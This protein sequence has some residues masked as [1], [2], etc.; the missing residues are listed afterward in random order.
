MSSQQAKPGPESLWVPA[1]FLLWAEGAGRGPALWWGKR[2]G[3]DCSVPTCPLLCSWQGWAKPIPVGTLRKTCSGLW[4]Y[5]PENN[6]SLPP[7]VSLTAFCTLLSHPS[8]SPC[9]FPADIHLPSSP[10][11]PLIPSILSL[12][13]SVP[14]KQPAEG[15]CQ[16]SHQLEMELVA[17]GAENTR[18]PGG[19]QGAKM[20]NE[21]DSAPHLS[22]PKLFEVKKC[23]DLGTTSTA[24]V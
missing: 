4:C 6:P 14:P 11:L 9:H 2:K 5:Q 17:C 23:L 10:S 20:E 13:W 19:G 15:H 8:T 21:L 1:P 3:G 24:T 18:S 12:R 22:V 7:S 16:R